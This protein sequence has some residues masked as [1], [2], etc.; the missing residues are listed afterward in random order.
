M[1]ANYHTYHFGVC[2]S[3]QWHCVCS[4]TRTGVWRKIF[5]IAATNNLAQASLCSLEGHGIGK[6]KR[7]SNEDSS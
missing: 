2:I 3:V 6:E 5:F 7:L 1:Q 4:C